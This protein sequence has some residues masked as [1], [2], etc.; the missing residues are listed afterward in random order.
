MVQIL[1]KLSTYF[2]TEPKDMVIQLL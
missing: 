1:S 2:Q